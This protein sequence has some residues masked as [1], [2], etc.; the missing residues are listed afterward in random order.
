MSADVRF[1]DSSG[2]GPST[3]T[4]QFIE[5]LRGGELVIGTFVNLGSPT[6]TNALGMAG[7]DFLL[8]DLEHGAGGEAGLQPQLMAAEAS[9]A[10][11]MVRVESHERIRIGRALDLGATAIMLPRIDTV[12]ETREAFTHL[13]YPP[14]GDRGV[15]T[16]NL[17]RRWGTRP[18]PFADANGDIAGI[19]QIETLS[20]LE[21]VEGIAALEGVDALFV[22]P[23]DLTHALG[24]PGDLESP[25]FNEALTRVL[26]ACRRS[27]V[28]AGILASGPEQALRFVDQGFS[29][30][31]VG[32]DAGLLI[33]AARS[34]VDVMRPPEG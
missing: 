32:S 15:S 20:A 1:P 22:G 5:K 29:L 9:G 18:G 7:L 3:P 2:T 4:A 23:S 33:S 30:L 25:A 10:A 12:A 27:G 28:P 21:E 31:V 13:R 34:V 26:A 14:L 17:A 8:V 24:V 11:V 6:V 19:V 16:A